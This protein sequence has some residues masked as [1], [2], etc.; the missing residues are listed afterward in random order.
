MVSKNSYGNK[1]NFS[2]GASTTKLKTS[3]KMKKK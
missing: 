3:K 1:G 2:K